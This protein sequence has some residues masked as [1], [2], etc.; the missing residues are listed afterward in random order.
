[1]GSCWC[2]TYWP[3]NK[4]ILTAPTH[5]KL[6]FLIYAWPLT[7]K[8]PCANMDPNFFLQKCKQQDLD[9]LKEVK[10]RHCVLQCHLSIFTLHWNNLRLWRV[11]KLCWVMSLS[12]MLMHLTSD[13]DLSARREI[14]G[15]NFVHFLQKSEHTKMLIPYS[16][17][18]ALPSW[19]LA[20]LIPLSLSSWWF[21]RFPAWCGYESSQVFASAYFCC[22]YIVF[23]LCLFVCK[24]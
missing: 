5:R 3:L 14:H 1:M 4:C 21:L 12:R 11:I 17:K 2:I 20:P 16:W 15:L 10:T 18:T 24:S 22:L 8:Y 23:F 7:L 19:Q 6:H 13:L 9:K